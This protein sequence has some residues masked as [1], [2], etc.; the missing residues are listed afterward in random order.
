MYGL[1]I[2]KIKRIRDLYKKHPNFMDKIFTEEEITYINK[3]KN[4]FERMA[5]IFAAKE[6]IIKANESQITFPPKEIEIFH[7]G[8]KP[9][10][11]FKDELYQLSIAHE[12]SYAI[13]FAKLWKKEIKI[14]EEFIGIIPKRNLNSHKGTYGKI[15][16]IGGSYGM[17]GSVY[18]SSTACLKSGAGLVYNIVD[19]EIFDIMTIK[20]I[21]PIAKSFPNT[22]ELTDFAKTLDILAIGPGMGT[23]EKSAEILRE[24]L[25]INKPLLIDA[26]GIN[27]LAKFTDPFKDREPFTSVLTPHPLEFARLT[28][29]DAAYINANREKVAKDYAK[30]NKVIL[31]LKGKGTVV[32]DGERVYINKS[33]NPGMSTAGAGDVLTGVISALLKIFSPFEAAKVGAYVHGLAGDFAKEEIGEISLRA[34]DIIDYLPRAFMAIDKNII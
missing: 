22:N 27:N 5:G 15:G 30:K 6:A 13:A 34:G 33:G 24:V 7:Q 31:L 32:T 20:Y 18:L 10:G 28:G 26:D 14:E 2:V 23:N 8:K 16:I 21:E 11:R 12:K 1:D 25:K 19:K 29:L 3:R 17:T 4:P 9:Y